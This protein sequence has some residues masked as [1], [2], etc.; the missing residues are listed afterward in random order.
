[1]KKL[2][3]TSAAVVLLALTAVGQDGGKCCKK[4]PK[5]NMSVCVKDPSKCKDKDKEKCAKMLAGCQAGSKAC[6]KKAGDKPAEAK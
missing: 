6:C 4:D 2:M 5:C 1:M 3:M